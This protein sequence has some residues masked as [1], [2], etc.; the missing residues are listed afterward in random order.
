MGNF[1]FGVGAEAASEAGGFGDKVSCEVLVEAVENVGVV[2]S[3]AGV[4]S[5]VWVDAGG[6]PDAVI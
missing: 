1:T 5:E 2:E 4:G 3:R 6:E